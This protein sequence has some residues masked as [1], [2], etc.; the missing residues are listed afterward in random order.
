MTKASNECDKFT[1][2]TKLKEQGQKENGIWMSRHRLAQVGY[3]Y[4]EI[5]KYPFLIYK[6]SPLAWDIE[7]HSH[8]IMSQEAIP[9]RQ[10]ANGNKA[11]KTVQN[12]SLKYG[13]IISGGPMFQRIE[14]SCIRCKSVME[15]QQKVK[16]SKRG[17]VPAQVLIEIENGRKDKLS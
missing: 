17:H 4:L 8:Y 10:S 16:S 3:P 14:D 7:I 13:V 15:G 5:N 6:D 1:K 9:D 11:W 12:H 2:E